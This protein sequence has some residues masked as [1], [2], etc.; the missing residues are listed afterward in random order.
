MTLGWPWPIL[1]QGQIW[2]HR[3]LKIIT[4]FSYKWLGHFEPNF[5][6]FLAQISGER[7]S[8]PLVLWLSHLSRRLKDILIVNQRSGVRPSVNHDV[9]ISLPKPHGQSKSFVGSLYGCWEWKFIR[10]ILVMTKMAATPIYGQNLSKL[11]IETI[12]PIYTRLD[13]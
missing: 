6:L 13:M 4:G 12:G 11:F 1:R 8:G 7:F 2:K 9:Q 10:G 3:H 5:I